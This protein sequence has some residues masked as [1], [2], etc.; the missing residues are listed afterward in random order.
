V[1]AAED[2]AAA[3]GPVAASD[4]IGVSRATLHRRGRPP[5]PRRPRAPARSARA[6]APAERAA[7]LGLLHE[8]RFVDR[9]PASIVAVLLDEGRY[10]ASERT[11]YRLLAENGEVRE[12]RDQLRHPPRAVPRLCA[13][14]PR[15]V[16][17]WDITPLAG[18]ARGMWLHL[19]VM[20]DIFS[21]YVVAWMVASR[22]T[23]ALAAHFVDDA[24]RREGVRPG[25]LISH[26][27]RGAPMTSQSLALKYA[28]LGVTPSRSR[29]RVSDDNPFSEAQFK[30]TKYHPSYPDA[31]VDER[32]ARRH[33]ENFFR[34]Y[35]HEHRHGGIATLTPAD[36]HLGRVDSVIATRQAALDAAF[37]AHPERFPHGR[38]IHPRPDAEVWINP[39][40][41]AA[42]TEEART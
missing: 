20:L 28:E 40:P 1:R 24:V 35:N 34:W 36:V 21:R 5:V 11:L 6:L 12:R 7:A 27:D 17:S 2:L 42:A 37:A 38:P 18:P 41:A 32:H 10:L 23:G 19:Y 9:A 39:P 25:T 22:Q 4:A 3:V 33:F 29:P 14:A 30:T 16:W 8:E 15:E 31:F 26:S 13:K